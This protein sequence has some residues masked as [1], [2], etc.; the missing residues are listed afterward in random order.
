MSDKIRS[1]ALALGVLSPGRERTLE[2]QLSQATLNPLVHPTRR[3]SERKI[4]KNFRNL[5]RVVQSLV[6]TGLAGVFLAACSSVSAPEDSVS[7]GDSGEPRVYLVDGV[8]Y[9]AAEMEAFASGHGILYYAVTPE[10]FALG[11][12][13]VFTKEA[14]YLSFKAN[15]KADSEQGL[16]AQGRCVW[17]FGTDTDTRTTLYKNTGYGG[18]SLRLNKGSWYDRDELGSFDQA[19]SSVKGACSVW[20]DLYDNGDF[21]GTL[22][23][24]FGDNYRSLPSW[25]NNDASSVVVG[26]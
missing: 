20:T 21:T 23:S 4:M 22:W 26:N 8:E 9:A 5:R 24:T 10:A 18:D 19:V 1:T 12:A 11:Q 6:T 13:Y 16:T 2:Q 7:V 17:D 15:Y 3:K 14:D 25:M